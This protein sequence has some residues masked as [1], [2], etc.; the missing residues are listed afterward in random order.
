MRQVCWVVCGACVLAGTLWA[1]DYWKGAAGV[2]GDWNNSANW[3][4]GAVPENEIGFVN[5]GG[6]AV[7]PDGS[8]LTNLTIALGQDLGASGT[9]RIEPGAVITDT[10]LLPRLANRLF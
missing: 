8:F 6:Y 5:N 3:V 1:D 10:K 4:S 9:V 2:E 7:I